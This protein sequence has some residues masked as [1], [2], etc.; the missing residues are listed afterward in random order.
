MGLADVKDAFHRFNISKLYSSFFAL[1][2]VRG[3]EVG[4]LAPAVYRWAV[5]GAYS[6]VRKQSKRQCGPRQGLRN[7]RGHLELCRATFL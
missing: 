1:P 2:E 6:S 5:P 4:A 7:P 3:E